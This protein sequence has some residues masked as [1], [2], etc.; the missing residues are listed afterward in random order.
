MSDRIWRYDDA[1]L[2]HVNSIFRSLAYLLKRLNNFEILLQEVENL[3]EIVLNNANSDSNMLHENIEN[4]KKVLKETIIDLDS[5]YRKNEV[6]LVD[7]TDHINA[8]LGTNLSPPPNFDSLLFAVLDVYFKPRMKELEKQVRKLVDVGL[9][10]YFEKQGQNLRHVECLSESFRLL[11]AIVQVCESVFMADFEISVEF[12]KLASCYPNREIILI[13]ISQYNMLEEWGSIGHEIGHLL[14]SRLG[15]ELD[16]II[17]YL[18][19]NLRSTEK[20]IRDLHHDWFEEIFC[21]CVMTDLFYL[22]SLATVDFEHVLDDHYGPYMAKKHPP[23]A[24]RSIFVYEYLSLMQKSGDSPIIAEELGERVNINLQEFWL[25][26]VHQKTLAE[27]IFTLIRK[28]TNESRS[29]KSKEVISLLCAMW[30]TISKGKEDN[31]EY[32]D[33]TDLISQAKYRILEIMKPEK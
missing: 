20:E 22:G 28:S 15:N 21:D 3:D 5:L 33:Y 27:M 6:S 24:L 29:D 9:I 31:I 23:G 8:K 26:Q 12:D 19:D 16:D 30:Y 17:K 2:W 11:E 7:A 10:D 25:K 32:I 14:F 1:I 13:P 4:E 18:D